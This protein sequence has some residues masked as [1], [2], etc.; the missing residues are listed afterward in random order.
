MKLIIDI[1]EEDR[2][3]IANIHFVREDLKFKIGKAI[4]S[5]T[6]LPKGHGRLKDVDWIDD[7]C[8]DHRSDKDGSWCY[9]WRDI[10]GAPT[11]VGADTESEET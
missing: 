4:M 3:D 10:D 8:E 7:N 2:A 5:G 9:A 1:D 6:P 11:L